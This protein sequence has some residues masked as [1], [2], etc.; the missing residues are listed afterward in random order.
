KVSMWCTGPATPMG[1]APTWGPMRRSWWQ[2]R[3]GGVVADGPPDRLGAGRRGHVAPAA[4]A[5]DGVTSG[6]E[7]AGMGAAADG[8]GAG[9]RRESGGGQLDCDHGADAAGLPDR[10]VL[11]RDRDAGGRGCVHRVGVDGR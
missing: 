11:A 9:G 2:P 4:P 3:P 1:T 5:L 8:V 6:P 7:P 10:A